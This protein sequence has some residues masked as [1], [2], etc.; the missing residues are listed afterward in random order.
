MLFSFGIICGESPVTVDVYVNI[1]KT[2]KTGDINIFLQNYV[3]TAEGFW[4]CAH[5]VTYLGKEEVVTVQ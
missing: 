2:A 5:K 4:L 3:A 1:R